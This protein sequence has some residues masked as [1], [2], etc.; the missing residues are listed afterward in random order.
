MPRLDTI[1]EDEKSAWIKKSATSGQ[2]P[3]THTDTDNTQYL[4]SKW[5]MRSQG[6]RKVVTI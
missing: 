6:L 1:G 3:S 5:E 2:K 4:A